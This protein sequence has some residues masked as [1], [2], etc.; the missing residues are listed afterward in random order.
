MLK[1]ESVITRVTK[2]REKMFSP[3]RLILKLIFALA[4]SV[5]IKPKKLAEAFNL[6][7]TEDY[8]RELNKALMEKA[9]KLS[10]DN[11]KKKSK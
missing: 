2:V 7:A 9:N 10:D 4:I 3:R 6:K 1:T 8:A 5:K 11:T